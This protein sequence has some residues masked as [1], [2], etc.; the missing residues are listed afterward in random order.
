MK[1]WKSFVICKGQLL[2]LALSSLLQ[3]QVVQGTLDVVDSSSCSVAGWARDPQT[4]AS[5]Q[6][7]VYR[8]GD[9]GSGVLVTTFTANLL[10]SDL[11]FADQNHG[12]NQALGDN[13]LVADGKSHAIYAYGV[14]ASGATGP[15]AANGKA[16]QCAS[17]GTTLS[18]NVRDYGAKGDGISDDANAIQAAIDDTLPGGT[19]FIPAGTYMLG[20]GHYT[21]PYGS[22][23][24]GVTGESYAL[25]VSKNITLRGEGR[26]SIL[27]LMPVR[28]GIGSSL[29]DSF[30][31]EKLVVDGNGAARFR[32]NPATGLTYDWPEGLIVSGLWYVANANPGLKTIRDS[33]FRYGL[34]DG[35]SGLP[36]RDFS[37]QNVYIHDNG[38]SAFDPLSGF[39]GGGV[40]SSLNG[41]IGQSATDNVVIGNTSGLRVGFG[42]VGSVIS[43]NV[44]LN[45]CGAGLTLGGAE[46]TPPSQPESDFSVSHNWVEQNGT[47]CKQPG[48]LVWGGQHGRISSNYIFFN[49]ADT[50][51]LFADKGDGWPASID[52]QIQDNSLRYNKATGMSLT[53]RSSGIVLKGNEI[54]NNGSSLAGQ[55]YIAPETTSG[56]NADW[57]TANTLGY[58]APAAN[59]ATPVITPA[60]IVNAASGIGGGIAPGE[61]LVIYGSNLGPVQLVS[62][63]AN[64]DG[65]YERILAGTRV[66]FDGVPAAVWY[67]SARQVAVIAPY[68]L[69]WKDSTAVQVEYNGIKSSAV[70]VPIPPAAPGIFTADSSGKGQGALLNQDYSI[71]SSRN[72]A[73]R[74]SIVILYATGEGQTDPAGVD[75]Q[76]ATAGLPQPRLPVSVTIGGIA[77]EVLYAGAAPGFVAGS[78]QINARIPANAPTGASVS[79]QIS[80]GNAASLA[81]VTLSVN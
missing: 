9:A 81:G 43:Y 46:D 23:I 14:T 61:I 3:A 41:G 48:L 16:M 69:Y 24:S 36:T 65:R 53:M 70:T 59:P 66:L 75:G 33:E 15:L 26:N 8:D 38:A 42:S 56:V 77:A 37:L 2:A 4:T 73:G 57:A 12:F 74:G 78:M 44:V 52:W 11:P 34:E 79:V 32:R 20:T 21:L 72:P 19:V 47:V 31:F 80:I 25:K 6:V 76:L 13:P 63:A 64:S 51:M 29:A 22:P 58:T 45:S 10:R 5:I 40:A 39:H 60:G 17:I 49:V 35:P 55:V 30:L 67:A 68:Y 7:R 54:V 71:N 18:A 50:G 1:L 62:A 28:L 27:K